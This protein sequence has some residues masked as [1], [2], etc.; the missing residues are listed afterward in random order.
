MSEQEIEHNAVYYSR[1]YDLI[2]LG[3]VSLNDWTEL[4]MEIFWSYRL[5]SY[6][7]APGTRKFLM[8]LEKIGEL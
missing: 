7:Q 5:I 6:D 8:G 4:G 3:N 2:L 1:A